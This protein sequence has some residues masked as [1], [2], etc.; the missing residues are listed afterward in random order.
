MSRAASNLDNDFLTTL[1]KYGVGS[2]IAMYLVWSM[3]SGLQADVKAIRDEHKM[4]G[5]Y[6]QAI[7]LG[8]TT[9]PQQEWRCYIT[10]EN[11]RGHTQVPTLKY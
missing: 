4:M 7:C 8:V 10:T 11:W 3:T 9:D 5:Q 6:L 1:A 2:V